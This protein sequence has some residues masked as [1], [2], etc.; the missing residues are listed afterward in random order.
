MLGLGAFV[1]VTLWFLLEFFDPAESPEMRTEIALAV[2]IV[3]GLAAAVISAR[4][5]ERDARDDPRLICPHCDS[6]L[7]YYY[8][9][10]VLT[11]GNCPHCGEPVLDDRR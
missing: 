5:M 11:S 10:I 6:S 7:G 8:V 2:A 1:F 3:V 9:V 4:A